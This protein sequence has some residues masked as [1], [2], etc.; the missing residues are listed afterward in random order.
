MSSKLPSQYTNT[1]AS[2]PFVDPRSTASEYPAMQ[3]YFPINA[4]PLLDAKDAEFDITH[5][6]DREG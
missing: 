6:E 5:A 2:P 3:S 4:R 1:P